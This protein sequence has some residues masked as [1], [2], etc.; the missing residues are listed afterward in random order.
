M[1]TPVIKI[2]G[3]VASED[4]NNICGLQI[5]Q[6]NLDAIKVE[7]EDNAD[8]SHFVTEDDPIDT[9]DIV[10]KTEVGYVTYLSP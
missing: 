7:H 1:H 3:T 2:M 10:P 4:P 9:K 8:V 5:L 6:Q